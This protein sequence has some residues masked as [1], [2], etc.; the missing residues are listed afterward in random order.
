MKKLAYYLFP[1]YYQKTLLLRS[2]LSPALRNYLLKPLINKKMLIKDIEFLVLDFE[3]T[4]L[5][6]SKEKIISM[7]YTVIKDMHLLAASSQHL[8][9]NPEQSLT[10]E[11]VSIHQLTDDDLSQGMGLNDAMDKLFSEM[12]NRV[13]IAHFDNIE[14]RFIN[15]ACQK[16]Y[17]INCLPMRMLD[18]LKIEN[19]KMMNT[20][21]YIQPESLRLFSLREK[22]NLPRYKAHNAMQ[23]AISTA[24]LF[25]AQVS[26]MGD[27]NTIELKDLI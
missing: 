16:L 10:E 26:H 2:G 22:Y 4:G 25:L 7:G 24:E 19:R 5:H 6:P 1:K 20:K 8:L 13:V 9:I 21:G 17:K 11:N 12:Q 14:K 3:T 15:C 23:D 27:A 18:T